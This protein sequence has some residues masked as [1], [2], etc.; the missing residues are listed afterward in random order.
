[1]RSSHSLDRL[2][3]AFDD[4]RLVAD[5]GLLLPAT[6]AHHLGLKELVDE[7]LDLG[8]KV[9]AANAGDKLLTLVLS[10]LAGGDCIDDANALRAGGTERILGFRVKAA[11]TLGTFLRSFRWGHVRQLDRISRELLAR[12]WAAGACPGGEPFTI[13]LDSTICETGRLVTER[14]RQPTPQ[15]ATRGAVLDVVAN[16]VDTLEATGQL[17]PDMPGGAGFPSVI[18]AGRAMTA[19]H[20]KS[21]WIE[22]NIQEL[23]SERL[24]RQIVVL[25]DADAAGVAEVAYAAAK[26]QHGVVLLLDLGTGIGSALFTNGQLVPNMQLGHVELHGQDAEARLWPAARKRRKLGWKPWAAEFNELLARYEAYVWPDIIVIGGG[27]GE[28]LFEVRALLEI[29][30]PL[31]PATLGTTAGIVGAARVGGNRVRR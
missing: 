11:S 8:D 9:G 4:D 27:A 29:E 19:T 23:L 2:E 17:T 15:P 21:S 30:G 1:M 7:H 12:A 20:G 5:A 25:N 14:V 13:D 22:T 28:G 3:V 6:L 31:V 24:G 18:R 10:A 26:G 16:V